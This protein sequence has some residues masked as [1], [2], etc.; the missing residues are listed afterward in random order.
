VL[1]RE[2]EKLAPEVAVTHDVPVAL[3]EGI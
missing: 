3:G 1:A 2:G